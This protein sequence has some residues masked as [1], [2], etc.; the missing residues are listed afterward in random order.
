MKLN[1]KKLFLVLVL[2]LC[3]LASWAQDENY[4]FY[5]NSTGQTLYYKITSPT[6][7]E[8]VPPS[9]I[10][11]TGF[12]PPTGSLTIPSSVTNGGTPYSVTAIGKNAFFNCLALTSVSIPTSVTS[13]GE[14]AF[15]NCRGL[16]TLTI[17]NSVT[18]I[19][20]SAFASCHGLT[21][22][23][24]P[25]SVVSIENYTFSD[26]SGLTNVTIVGGV[27]SIGSYAFA[28][29][30]QL[31]HLIVP[32]S[33]NTIESNAFNGIDTVYY[34]QERVDG[35]PW[36]ARVVITTN[37][38]VEGDPLVYESPYKTMV[39]GCSSTA[40]SVTI[41]NTV[42]S[43]GYKAFYYRRD[44]TSVTIPNSVICI[45]N[46]AFEGCSGLTGSLTIP[47]SVTTIENH[48]FEG[49]TNV[50]TLYYNATNLSKLGS[51][52]T[53]G[54]RPMQLQTLVIGD[55]VETLPDNVFCYQRSLTGSLT[56]PESVTSIGVSAFQGCTGLT[57]VTLPNSVT[58]IGSSTFFSCSGLTSAIIPE[59]VTRIEDQTFAGCVSLT[60]VTLPNSLTSIGNSAFQNCTSLI[61]VTL[62]NSLTAIGDNAFQNCT[63]LANVTIGNSVNSIGAFAFGYCTG[64][65]SIVIGK[66]V[67]SI[68][69]WA[70]D[71]CASLKT[72][73]N[74]SENNIKQAQGTSNFGCVALN[75]KRVLSKNNGFSD[76]GTGSNT[77]HQIS[78][79]DYTIVE[80]E[81]DVDNEI[82]RSTIPANFIYYDNGAKDG[83]GWMA[84]EIFLTDDTNRFV[85][86]EEFTAAKATYSRE[87]TNSN[88]STLCLPFTAA[89]PEGFEVYD[90]A[91][92][93]GHTLTF[94]NH[95]GDI[96]AYTP[97]LVDYNLS[98]EGS[99]TQCTITQN[100]A[101]F[102]QTSAATPACTTTYNGMTFKGTTVRTCMTDNNYGYK[103]GF[104]VQSANGSEHNA[105]AHVNPF[106]CYFAYTAPA[107]SSQPLPQTLNVEVGYGD[108]VGIDAVETPEQEYDNRYGNDVYDMLGRLVRKNATNLEGLPKG[109]YIWKGKK[110]V[111][112]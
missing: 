34:S 109:V 6:T 62:P 92:F 95:E 19:G 51:F 93:D 30:S 50:D 77:I 96:A 78:T 68:G 75:A 39:V 12:T 84:N 63:G 111:V 74:L 106:R 55:N 31:T 80:E 107:G 70:F 11:W 17:P 14:G 9:G 52:S 94:F 40:T 79:D 4:D 35:S 27:T 91:G 22:V 44:L 66:S 89:V 76:Y 99:T 67:N 71:G 3:S 72:I 97:Y 98:K 102:P 28:Y 49:C 42:I 21:N 43:I 87:F 73:Y 2:C 90:F 101:L 41:P 5:D 105:H 69:Q 20:E 103:D 86:P 25:N 37:Y 53:E 13:I 29:C 38:E 58:S 45:G 15:S 32:R 8:V 88:R 23:T 64:L 46:S 82:P 7:V 104:F 54:F 100:D 56:I 110:I 33:V 108:P 47:E 83:S 26:C 18:S 36:G 59:S 10:S 1:M 57:N 16:I 85:A 61:H 81:R 48:A 24:I 65:A 112:S 60:D